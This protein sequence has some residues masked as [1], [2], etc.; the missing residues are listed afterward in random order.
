MAHIDNADLS[1]FQDVCGLHDFTAEQL[2]Y[3]RKMARGLKVI[4][5]DS[6]KREQQRLAKAGR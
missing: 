6:K 2:E 4:L 3:I 1:V 5:E